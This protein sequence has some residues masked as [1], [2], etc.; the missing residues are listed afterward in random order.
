[1]LTLLL[2]IPIIG[3]LIISTLFSYE[4][5]SKTIK[6]IKL[7]A[8]I[9]S[10]LNLF[11]SLTIFIMF[12]FTNNQFQF[13]QEYHKLGSYDIFLSLDGVSMYFLLFTT[14]I[15]TIVVYY[16]GF[17]RLNVRLLFLSLLSSLAQTLFL[18]VL[19]T[20]DSS[21]LYSM[22][23]IIFNSYACFVCLLTLSTQK[24]TKS[25][26]KKQVYNPL[27]FRRHI[28]SNTTFHIGAG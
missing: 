10:L 23:E 22:A 24:I 26:C 15:F 1:M 13:I 5:S 3:I 8:L 27:P 17:I 9:T 6:G 14:L 21:V 4:N 16:F 2:L 18:T 7:T 11:L 28:T 25:S 12:D 20:L 19:F